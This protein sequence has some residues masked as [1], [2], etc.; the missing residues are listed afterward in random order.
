MCRNMR[1]IADELGMAEFHELGLRLIT[2]KSA[3]GPL[4]EDAAT[5]NESTKKSIGKEM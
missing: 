2:C 3:V 5:T 4:T 1:D